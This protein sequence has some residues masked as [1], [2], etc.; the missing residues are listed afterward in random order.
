MQREGVSFPE[1]LRMLAER[2]GINLE[3]EPKSHRG[4]KSDLDK[5]SLF[6]AMAWSVEQFA[7]CFTKS[8]EA[9]EARKYVQ[10]RGLTDESI[11]RFQIGFAPESWS[12]L[13]DRGL[14]R[15]LSAEMLESIG[16]VRRNERGKETI[17]VA[18]GRH[19]AAGLQHRRRVLRLP[20]PRHAGLVR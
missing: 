3:T 2:A 4:A 8:D 1:A 19:R 13:I 20:A 9:A 12:W 7:Q 5:K 16:V 14:S 6:D 11:Q 15:G 17:L 10:S 18:R